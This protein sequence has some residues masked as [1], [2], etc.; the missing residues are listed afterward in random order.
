MLISE[1]VVRRT[2]LCTLSERTGRKGSCTVGDEREWGGRICGLNIEQQKRA[3]ERRKARDRNTSSE[4]C[5]V[6]RKETAMAL[7]DSAVFGAEK[8]QRRDS[9]ARLFQ[10]H[11]N[12][13]TIFCLSFFLTCGKS[14]NQHSRDRDSLLHTAQ[15]MQPM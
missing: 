3:R 2:S 15:Q 9:H 13:N 11:P 4:A 6:L 10:H 7:Y 1:G 5:R 14:V 8:Q 12:I